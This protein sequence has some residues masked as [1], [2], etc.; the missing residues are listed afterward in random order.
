[1][2]N[3]KP[4]L[5]SRNVQTQI[6]PRH[7]SESANVISQYNIPE[8]LQGCASIETNDSHLHYIM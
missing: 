7:E 5:A 3:N 6:F 4:M 8:E 2:A 1:M